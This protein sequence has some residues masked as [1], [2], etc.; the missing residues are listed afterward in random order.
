MIDC[1]G[2]LEIF[3]AG[4]TADEGSGH[5]GCDELVTAASVPQKP[6]QLVVEASETMGDF[7]H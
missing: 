7:G 1:R 3:P 2:L 6:A 5:Q 4:S